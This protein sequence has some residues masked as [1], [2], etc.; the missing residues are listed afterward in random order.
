MTLSQFHTHSYILNYFTWNNLGLKRQYL[1]IIILNV[2]S[3]ILL[4]K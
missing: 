4:L 3:K 2:L 1:K